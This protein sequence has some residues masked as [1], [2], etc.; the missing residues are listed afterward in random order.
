MFERGK[1]FVLRFSPEFFKGYFSF[2]LDQKTTAL[3][4]L[5]R[6]EL[7]ELRTSAWQRFTS[8]H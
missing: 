4:L 3:I 8:D 7:S 1:L 6:Q 2:I 5:I